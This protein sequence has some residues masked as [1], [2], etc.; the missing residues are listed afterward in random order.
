MPRA[1]PEEHLENLK[2]KRARL[3]AQIAQAAARKREAARK[4]LL[5]RKILAGGMVLD[6][7]ERGELAERLFLRDMDK[8]L[9][10]DYERALFDLPPRPPKE[11]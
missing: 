11:D 5:K 4:R 9:V 7:V 2:N 3:D 1:N 10:R 6:R 8:Y